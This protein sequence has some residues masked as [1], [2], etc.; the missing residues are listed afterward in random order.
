VKAIDA[1]GSVLVASPILFNAPATATID[2]AIPLDRKV[3]PSLFERIDAA[4][5]PLLGN[6]AIG[7]LEEDREHQDLTFLSGETGHDKRDLARFALAH[8]LARHGIEPEF[9]FVLLGGSL[10]DYA[11]SASL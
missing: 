1:D 5:R 8:R 9:W 2:L 10:F 3:P 11:E 7:E 4:V 6:V